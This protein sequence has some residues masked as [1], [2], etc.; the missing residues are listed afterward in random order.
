MAEQLDAIRD[1]LGLRRR[2]TDLRRRLLDASDEGARV[3]ASVLEAQAA[4]LGPR[5]TAASA[6]TQEA[7]E[8]AA[9]AWAAGDEA[10]PVRERMRLTALY[11]Q[12]VAAAQ[13]DETGAGE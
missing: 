1:L 7:L 8:A 11:D 5:V 12:L 2:F 3:E 10:E 13:A 6:R 9:A 4:A